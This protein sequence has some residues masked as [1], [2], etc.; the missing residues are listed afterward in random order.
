LE[1]FSDRLFVTLP[2]DFNSK[3]KKLSPINRNKYK[4]EEASSL[5]S[6]S[7]S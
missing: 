6:L 7:P 4:K 1:A 5:D 2:L 3:E